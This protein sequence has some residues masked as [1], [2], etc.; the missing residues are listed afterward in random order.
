MDATTQ[1]NAKTRNNT[2]H[3]SRRDNC[4]GDAAAAAVSLLF[5]VIVCVNNQE[6]Y[7]TCIHQGIERRMFL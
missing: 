1:E 3:V 5:V 2:L 4:G 6:Q 7:D